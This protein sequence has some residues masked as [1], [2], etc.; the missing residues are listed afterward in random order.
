[1]E[2]DLRYTSI[3][4]QYILSNPKS[5][6]HKTYWVFKTKLLKTDISAFIPCIDKEPIPEKTFFEYNS[7]NTFVLTTARKQG[8][9]LADKLKVAFK[10]QT[11]QAR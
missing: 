10:D 4:G 8:K 5:S 6:T 11:L 3:P 7:A 1:M 9:S 2:V